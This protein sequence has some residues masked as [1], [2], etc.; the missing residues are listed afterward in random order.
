MKTEFQ[1]F[2]DVA[3]TAAHKAGGILRGYF[4]VGVSSAEK[5]DGESR[6]GS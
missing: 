4:E 1:P 5:I 3:Q 6:Q 2:L